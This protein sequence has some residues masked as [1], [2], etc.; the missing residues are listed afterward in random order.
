MKIGLCVVCRNEENY[1]VGMLQSALGAV[2]AVYALDNG[3]TDRSRVLVSNFCERNAVPLQLSDE[4]ISLGFPDHLYSKVLQQAAIDGCDWILL[5]DADE[6]LT[7][8]GRENLRQVVETPFDAFKLSRYTAITPYCPSQTMHTAPVSY[9]REFYE[10]HWRLF[11]PGCVDYVMPDGKPQPH[12]PASLQT[13][14]AQALEL[15]PFWI[16]QERDGWEQLRRDKLR[17]QYPDTPLPEL[18]ETIP[19]WMD[20][21]ALYDAFITNCREG[22]TLVELGNYCGRSL[23]YL[24]LQARKAEKDVRIFGADL[25]QREPVPYHH[26]EV[27]EVGARWLQVAAANIHRAGLADTVSLLQ[28]DSARAARL[29]DDGSVD[30]CFIDA[31]HELDFVQADIQAWW[32]KVKAGGIFAGHDYSHVFPGVMQAVGEFAAAEGLVVDGTFCP[33]SWVIWKP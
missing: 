3:S 12:I 32:P 24:G 5:L 22:G 26:E 31:C 4:P 17:G 28:I 18:W 6:R 25:F 30:C 2:D 15:T 7:T 9:G 10:T 8:Y 21:E 14:S 1:I 13:N 20:Y 33:G 16:T 29:F 19:G 23:V 11:K 27:S